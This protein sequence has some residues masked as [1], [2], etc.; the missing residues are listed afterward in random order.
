MDIDRTLTPIFPDLPP[1]A[2]TRF[3]AIPIRSPPAQPRL[4]P[5]PTRPNLSLYPTY[6]PH[7]HS[8]RQSSRPTPRVRNDAPYNRPPRAGAD[9]D[10][11]QSAGP[12]N[13]GGSLAS[14]L[15][16]GGARSNNSTRRAQESTPPLLRGRSAAEDETAHKTQRANLSNKLRNEGTKEW[17]RARVIA[18]GAM[19]MS[20]SLTHFLLYM[21][22]ADSAE[23]PP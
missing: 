16:R 21:I 23:T 2:P 19:D 22:R 12:S 18:P 15:S 11:G 20:A 7:H 4:H 8:H 13:S 17:L 6:H 5:V 1:F 3:R 14:R 10:H 9:R